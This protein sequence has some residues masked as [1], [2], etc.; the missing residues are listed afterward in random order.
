MYMIAE[1]D[2]EVAQ[3]ETAPFIAKRSYK[4][5]ILSMLNEGKEVRGMDGIIFT[6]QDVAK[7][8]NAVPENVRADYR[9]TT[10][11]C[12][13]DSGLTGILVMHSNETIEGLRRELL[14]DPFM[15]STNNF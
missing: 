6:L 2:K 1:C 4:L 13:K 5:D 8:C 10:L 15:S 7:L 12:E 14:A 9:R 3:G 11:W